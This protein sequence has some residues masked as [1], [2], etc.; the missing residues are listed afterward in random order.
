MCASASNELKCALL[1]DAKTHN[2]NDAIMT[3]RNERSS[4][5][6]DSMNDW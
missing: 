1:F 5:L 3:E 6:L 4:P 2:E